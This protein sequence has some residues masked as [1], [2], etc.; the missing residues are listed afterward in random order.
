M[1][2]NKLLLLLP[3]LVWWSI[4]FG[5]DENDSTGLSINVSP[6]TTFKFGG[7]V[8]INYANQEWV[9]PDEGRKRGLRF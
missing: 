2:A 4:S 9:S 6:K 5:Q 1:K 3:L 7:A 8:W